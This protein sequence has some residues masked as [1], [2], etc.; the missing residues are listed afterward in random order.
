V[1][2]D[3]QKR[4]YVRL[5]GKRV[6]S[7]AMGFFI[8]LKMEMRDG[9]YRFDSKTFDETTANEVIRLLVEMLY[10]MDCGFKFLDS[11]YSKALDRI[12]KKRGKPERNAIIMRLK[13]EGLSDAQIGRHPDVV[14]ANGGEKVKR[15]TVEQVRRAQKKKKSV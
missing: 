2:K 3:K 14:K 7:Q 13:S 11:E 12:P 15:G 6:P 4:E 8:D 10:D 5:F 1:A 9:T